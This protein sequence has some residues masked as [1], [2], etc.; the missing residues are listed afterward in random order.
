MDTAYKEEE[1]Q[2]PALCAFLLMVF[3]FAIDQF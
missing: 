1:E 3:Y 2:I